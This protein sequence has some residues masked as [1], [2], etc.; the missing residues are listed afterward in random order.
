[1]SLLRRR[2][3]AKAYLQ[4]TNEAQYNDETRVRTCKTLMTQLTAGFA[5]KDLRIL[6]DE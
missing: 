1:M 5:A 2:H 3:K 6:C 4:C